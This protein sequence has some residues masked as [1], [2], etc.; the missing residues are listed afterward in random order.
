MATASSPPPIAERQRKANGEGGGVE[1]SPPPSGP[2]SIPT[3]E[4]PP[5]WEIF[6]AMKGAKPRLRLV[7]PADGDMSPKPSPASPMSPPAWMPKDAKA[8]WRRV[9]PVLTE[10]RILTAADLGCLESYCVAIG[11]VQACQRV[12]TRARSMFVKSDRSAPRPH[13]A[14]RVMHSAMTQARQLAAELGL[15][16]VSRSRPAIAEHEDDDD[17]AGLVD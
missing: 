11:Q 13:P 4:T 10:R 3:R 14:I 12:L 16:P 15:T 8:E 2:A 5:D 7:S 9:M 6:G 1:L 17:F